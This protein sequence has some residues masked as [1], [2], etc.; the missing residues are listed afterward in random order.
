MSFWVTESSPDFRA[1]SIQKSKVQVTCSKLFC[2]QPHHQIKLGVEMQ[3]KP[4]LVA[5]SPLLGILYGS[6]G[7]GITTEERNNRIHPGGGKRRVLL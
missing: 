1:L 4:M 2:W 7:G 3:A 5:G 6:M